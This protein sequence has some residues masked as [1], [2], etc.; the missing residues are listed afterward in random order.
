MFPA[1]R[2]TPHP[3]ELHKRSMTPPRPLESWVSNF[4]VL[5][6]SSWFPSISS[7][8]EGKLCFEAGDLGSHNP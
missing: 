3:I 8:S 5:G 1:L 7:G 4:W 6:V 2:L